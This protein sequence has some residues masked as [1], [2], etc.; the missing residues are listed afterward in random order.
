[1]MTPEEARAYG[2][3]IMARRMAA[4]LPVSTTQPCPFERMDGEALCV[5]CGLEFQRHPSSPEGV[6][7]HI[8]C[9][10]RRLKL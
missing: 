7:L 9:D 3:R 8:A 4:M 1:M 2:Y 6:G 10:G 5:Q